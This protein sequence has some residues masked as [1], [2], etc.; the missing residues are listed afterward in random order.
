M[1]QR[2]LPEAV[3]N[4]M[5]G[6]RAH[7]LARGLSYQQLRT[8]VSAGELVQMRRGSYVTRSA[9]DWAA[10][11]PRRI[12]VLHVYMAMDLVGQGCVASFQS[13]AVMHDLALFT[14]PGNAVTLTVPPGGRRGSRA[15]GILVRTAE[16]PLVHRDT[17]FRVPVTSPT[18]TV[19]DLARTL[20]FMEGV[21]VADSA[22]HKDLTSGPEVAGA[23][24]LCAAWTGV[25][26]ARRVVAFASP[27]AESA[28]ESCAR[29][30]FAR[31][32]K[33]TPEV[34]YS[35]EGPG[36]RFTVDLYYAKHRTIVELDGAV[37][38]ETKKDLLD[39]FSRDRTLRDAG[40][41]VVHVTWKELFGTPELV[42]GRIRKAFAAT[43][44]V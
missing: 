14:R 31:H 1:T 17:M 12:H 40:Y 7:W 6:T 28:F 16:L 4:F 19:A 42:I 10:G 11:D 37:K 22:M 41:K 18:R 34:Q 32:I 26:R 36:Y 27:N 30:I 21:V 2:D 29:V 20:P 39:Q 33:E 15:G 13:A 38:Y 8:L 24:E 43:S 44:P 9:L 5:V 23:L 25:A 3:G 35:I